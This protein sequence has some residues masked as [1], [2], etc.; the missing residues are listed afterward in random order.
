MAHLKD[1]LIVFVLV[2]FVSGCAQLGIDNPFANDPLTGGVDASTSRLLGVKIPA[3]LQVYP[4][5]GY[6]ETTPAGVRQGLETYRGNIDG[7]AA[8]LNLFNTLQQH[9]WELRMSLRKGD[10]SLALYQ[11][12]NDFAVVT[13]HRQGMLT[14]L[15]IWAGPKLPDGSILGYQKSHENEESGISM[16]GEEY[17]PLE[18]EKGDAPRQGTV[19][20]WGGKLE[21][22]EL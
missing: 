19:E 15:E 11:R 4:S 17:G 10:R 1:S 6:V 8:A 5:H 9:G 2:F 16:P 14:I 12:D 3:G 13:F 7:T 20:Q 22:R 21:E 18:E